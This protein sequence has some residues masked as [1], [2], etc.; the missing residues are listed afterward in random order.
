MSDSH[1]YARIWK[2]SMWN[3]CDIGRGN[4]RS[5]GTRTVAVCHV[6]LVR[7]ASR[8][9]RPWSRWSGAVPPDVSV[10]LTPENAPGY[11]ESPEDVLIGDSL[12]GMTSDIRSELANSDR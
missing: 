10:F 5:P 2:W 1:R 9:G 4:S 7:A 6:G 8:S 11:P 3:E 12:P